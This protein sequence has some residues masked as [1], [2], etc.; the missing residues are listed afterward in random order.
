[1]ITSYNI[2]IDKLFNL[3]HQFGI[4]LWPS[5]SPRNYGLLSN[6]KI[7]S[8]L[9]NA[10]NVQF[11]W[12]AIKFDYNYNINVHCVLIITGI[13]VLVLAPIWPKAS[14]HAPDSTWHIFTGKSFTSRIMKFDGKNL[15]LNRKSLNYLISAFNFV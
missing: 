6:H 10:L 2:L 9:M 1:M 3:F 15:V 7:E 12:P 13:C 5:K 14:S 8:A 4:S 11:L